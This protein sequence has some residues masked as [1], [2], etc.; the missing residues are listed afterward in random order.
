MTITATP[1][2]Y[3][4][5]EPVSNRL[6]WTIQPDSADVLETVGSFATVQVTFP[7]SGITVPANGTE[8]TLWGHTFT[9]DDTT[10]FT[11][12]SFELETS[13]NASGINFKEMLKANFFFSK[14]VIS[15]G[16]G[17]NRDTIITWQDC[18][19]QENFTGDAMDLSALVTAGAT[20]TVTNGMTAVKVNGYVLQA[21][22]LK[23]DADGL[24]QPITKY[25]GFQPVINCNAVQALTIDFM[26]EARRT[27][28]TSIP[29]LTVTSEQDPEDTTAV[30]MFK[31]QIGW[32]YKDENCQPLSGNFITSDPVM[33]YNTVFDLE[34]N[35][36]MK[37]FIYDHTE[38]TP[39]D[40]PKWP[41]WLTN[42]PERL[43]LGYESIAW[44]WC[45]G[46]YNERLTP[47][48]IELT[49]NVYY[50]NGTT[51]QEKVYYPFVAEWQLH[52]FNVSPKRLLSLFSLV[53]L[54]TVSHYF[55]RAIAIDEFNAPIGTIGWETYFSVESPC[56]DTTDLYFMT[57]YGGIGTMFCDIVEKSLNQS[58]N[59]ICLDVPVM[60]TRQE[61]ARY[62]GYM[63]N[64]VRNQ[65]SITLR[66]RRNYSKEEV[67]Y[68]KSF[69]ASPE[70]W[71]QVPETGLDGSGQLYNYI[72]K[73]FLVDPGGVQ[74][75]QEGDYIELIVTGKIGNE[76]I[77]QNPRNA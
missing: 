74:I 34:E 31:L 5:P 18:G 75:F 63:Q 25:E 73:R 23:M 52:N 24:Y 56:E 50:K 2:V 16:A 53:D 37:R 35:W 70:R 38:I 51:D 64:Q 17:G 29:D 39:F 60:S 21:R 28:Y 3:P 8:F 57:P 65:E 69:K 42:K 62:G 22:L 68:F 13:G 46:A 48:Q 27:I 32:T 47:E 71:I 49:F 61:Q 6:A 9:I 1:A 58:A 43:A 67:A 4:I 41:R 66:C 77:V 26:E 36:G 19:E 30:G 55:V 20:V 7:A 14:T 11:Q 10:S 54:S 15:N 33:V 40:I 45:S 44:L 72:A 59:E 76:I 12:N